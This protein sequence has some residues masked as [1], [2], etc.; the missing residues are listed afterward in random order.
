MTS[1]GGLL[2]RSSPANYDFDIG[3]RYVTVFNPSS[4]SLLPDPNIEIGMGFPL[5]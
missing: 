3:F 2:L 4:F 5:W 1:D